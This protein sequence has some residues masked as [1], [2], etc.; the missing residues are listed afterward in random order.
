M[1][2]SCPVNDSTG[3]CGL[4]ESSGAGL[5]VFF[6][7]L[8]QGLPSLLLILIIVGIIGAIGLAIAFVIKKSIT[9]PVRSR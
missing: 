8:A 6:Q 7:Y 2:I 5:G 3:V 9:N 1:T 4:M